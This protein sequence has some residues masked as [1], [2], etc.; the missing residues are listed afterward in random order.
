V[1]QYPGGATTTTQGLL[2]PETAASQLRSVQSNLAAAKEQNLPF[3]V[4]EANSTFSGGIDGVSNKYASA[5]WSMD[6]AMQLA[7]A[8]VSGINIHGGLGVCN[9]PIF[10]GRFQRYTPFCAAT[11]EDELAQRY[12]AMPIYYGLW[13]ARQMGPGTFL[14]LNLT[15]DRNITAYAVK[16]D[17]GKTRITVIQKDDTS[18]APVSLNIA[19]GNRVRNAEVLRM[20]GTALADETTTIQGST[21]DRN[22]KL[23]P[24]RPDQVRVRNGSLSVNVAAGSAVVITLDGNC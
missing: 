3:R 24:K 13:M 18:A 14:P 19:V 15:T 1:H 8:G 2:S 12:K 6:Y 10:N 20:T 7:Q 4:D 23:N 16:G 9:E 11:K 5:L 17:D 22:G 21:V